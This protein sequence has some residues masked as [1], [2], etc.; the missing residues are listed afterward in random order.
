MQR[1]DEE[2]PR[3]STRRSRSATTPRP[4]SRSPSAS[5]AARS[6]SSAA[7]GRHRATVPV[8]LLIDELTPEKVAELLHHRSR[9]E[10]P[11]GTRPAERR[12]RLRAARPLRSLRAA[13][14]GN[15]RRASPKRVSLPRGMKPEDVDLAL[16]PATAGAA[17]HRSVSIPATA[18]RSTAG[19]GPLRPL[20]AARLA[21]QERQDARPALRHHARGG[22]AAPRA[23]RPD[24]AQG[25]RPAPR[26]GGELRILAGRFGPYVTDGKPQRQPADGH[27]PRGDDAAEQAVALLA[28]KGKPR[29]AARGAGAAPR[30]PPTAAQGAGPEEEALR[31][32]KRTRMVPHGAPY[33]R[34]NPSRSKASTTPRMRSSLRNSSASATARSSTAPTRTKRW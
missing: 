29:A 18:R 11:L 15:R 4:G 28:E 21:V 8:D 1:I 25:A 33:R 31:V 3:S 34:L 5:A 32:G 6:T 26:R 17:A 7:R 23:D 2:L 12:E 20:R 14:R 16:G 13:R 10:E 30:D 27:R 9:G 19:I 22:A 24:G